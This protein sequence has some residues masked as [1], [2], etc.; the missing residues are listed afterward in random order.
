MSATAAALRIGEVARRV[1]TT[2]RTIRY[3]EEIGLLPA[4]GERE[5]GRHRL[6]SERDVERLRD[7]LRLKELLGVS[8]DEL[9]ALLEAEEA[10]AAIRDEWRH[11]EPDAAR[12]RALLDESLGHLERQLELVRRRRDEIAALESDLAATRRRVLRRRRELRDPG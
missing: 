6:Y 10:R 2:P 8:L 11:G 9:K 1:G 5:S 7:A 12:R 3:Y 4:A